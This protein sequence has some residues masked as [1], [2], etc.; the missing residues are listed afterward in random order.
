MIDKKEI[1][2]I[3]KIFRLSGPI[4]IALGDTVRQKLVIDMATAGGDGV[5]VTELAAKSYL[6]RPAISHHLKVLKDSGIV[7]SY[8]KGTQVFYHLIYKKNLHEI[9]ELFASLE[10]II[11]TIEES[12]RVAVN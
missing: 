6:S 8:K 9:Q 10:N 4:F 3:L 1:R 2:R 5:N 11:K 7:D 12:S